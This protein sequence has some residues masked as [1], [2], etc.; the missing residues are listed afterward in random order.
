MSDMKKFIE[1]VHGY[2][3]EVVQQVANFAMREF[4]A[5]GDFD[6]TEEEFAKKHSKFIR[7]M[8]LFELSEWKQEWYEKLLE[9]QSCEAQHR[10]STSKGYGLNHALF[11]G[12]LI[13]M[14]I[15]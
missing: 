2:D 4:D 12:S 15:V 9:V 8:K 10:L 7:G 5:N 14:T 11:F 1:N 3:P 13:L 6:I